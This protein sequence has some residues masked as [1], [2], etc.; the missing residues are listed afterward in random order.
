MNKYF[1]FTFNLII[2]YLIALTTNT[3]SQNIDGWIGKWAGELIIYNAPGYEK[4]SSLH[5]ELHISK[6]DSAGLYNWHIIYG[7]S[8]KDHRKYLLRTID[9][10]MG[11]YS[12]D[13]KNG[14]LLGADMLGS[15][16][17]SRFIVQ[18]SMLDITYEMENDK[19]I[20]E[21]FAGS[22]TPEQTTTGSEE[23][24]SVSS[25]KVTNYQKA[26]LMKK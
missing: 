3:Y 9:E 2:S 4:I 17:I 25:F 13:E 26:V 7:D 1:I 6:T 23:N 22:D 12:I 24:I 11:K 10:S 14:I 8:A 16:L 19:I 20:F 5:M 18:G 21:V 15:K